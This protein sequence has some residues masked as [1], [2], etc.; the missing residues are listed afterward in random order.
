MSGSVL[1]QLTLDDVQWQNDQWQVNVEHLEV[2]HQWTCLLSL[3]VCVDHLDL[4]SPHIEQLAVASTQGATNDADEPEARSST[5]P[6]TLPVSAI[7]SNLTISNLRFIGL[8]QQVFL[9]ELNTAATL[10][11]DITL[12]HL[13]LGELI[14]NL[15]ASEPAPQTPL[16][17]SYQGL[18]LGQIATPIGV[19]LNKFTLAHLLVTQEEAALM[20]GSLSLSQLSF[21][22]SELALTEL[23]S[24]INHIDLSLSASAQLD[25]NYPVTVAGQASLPMAEQKAQHI[26]LNLTGDLGDLTA[27]IDASG[28]YQAQLSAKLN[29]LSDDLPLTIHLQ[30]PEQ[31]IAPIAQVEGATLGAGTGLIS[32]E[33][34]N[35]RINLDSTAVVAPINDIGVSLQ[36]LVTDRTIALSALNIATLEG[37]LVTKGTAYFEEQLSWTGNTRITN[38]STTRL[39]E[40]GPEHLTGGFNT[41]V[42]MGDDG[43]NL[44]LSAL[45]IQGDYYDLP[46]LIT[47]DAVYSASSDIMVTNLS[48]S[49]GENTLSAIAQII[50]QQYLDGLLVL[51]MTDLSSLYPDISG[52]ITGT[53]SAKGKWDNPTLDAAIDLASLQISST[54]NEALAQQGPLN[55]DVSLKGNL[56]E[57]FLTTS[58]Q[59]PDHKTTMHLQ[60]NWQDDAWVGVLDQTEVNIINTIW[61][62]DSQL[63]IQF[64]PDPLDVTISAHCW[65]SR[66]DGKFCID[67]LT[68]Q[69]TGA[70]WQI[71]GDALPLGLWAF[72]LFPDL[73]AQQPSSTLTFSST[74]HYVPEQPIEA[75]FDLSVSPDTWHLGPK[76]E[77]VVSLEKIT[78]S[79]TYSKDSLAL[80]S[81]LI[82]TEAGTL[83]LEATINSL[84][85]RPTISGEMQVNQW[86]LAPFKPLSTSINTLTG[87]VNGAITFTGEVKQPSLGGSVTIADGNI[88]AEGLPV[89]V[90]QWQQAINFHGQT[91]DFTG[92]FLL[93]DGKGTL[94]GD[95]N[96]SS[97]PIINLVLK[98]DSFAVRQDEIR[99]KV[100]PNLKASI[101]PKTVKVTGSVAIPYA[102]I[103]IDDLP[104]SAVSPS[105]DVHLRG[106]PPSDNFMDLVDAKVMVEID[107]NKT[108][109]VKLDAFGLTASLYGSLEI[110]TLPAL[111]GY[112]DIQLLNG[113]YK[114]YGQNLIIRTGEIQFNG[115]IDQPLLLVEAIRDPDDT[116]DDVVAGIRI[117]GAVEQPNVTLFSEPTMEQAKNLAYLL[118]GSAGLSSSDDEMDEN[119]YA[120]MLLGFGLSSSESLTSNVGESLGIDDLSLTTTGQGDDTK[121]AVSGRIAKNLTIRYGVGVFADTSDG[122]QE[123]ALRYQILPDLYIEIVRSLYTAVDMYYQFTL[124]DR[125]QNDDAKENEAQ[126]P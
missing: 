11:S 85:E 6:L 1:N 112:G 40:N 17:L 19:T 22:G 49:Q 12:S 95:V 99:L 102:R 117:D 37:Q 63:Q 90:N 9:S 14:V 56:K 80:T 125:S 119:A 124:G 110:N 29:L 107:K 44:V 118:N 76:G 104:P 61:A 48:A 30:W 94:S 21:H 71:R 65:H 83:N 116:D 41:A 46:T 34:G 101:S 16:I 92:N 53:V 60:G 115:P 59:V 47:G 8:G 74:G 52:A 79:G 28:Q 87:E 72:E 15:A 78:T 68:A 121:V 66:A 96:W 50:D 62:L 109:D 39:M 55:G 86:Q 73:V 67:S 70:D 64:K 5:T 4:V 108:K 84:T 69:T 114:A 32:G 18:N 106:E 126:D 45:N 27:E 105:S 35:Y 100:S 113:L 10:D 20:D 7:V 97:E 122:G 111:I 38:V 3:Q 98:G 89:T 36:A 25:N 81:H 23:S 58:L 31:S 57:H 13:T 93:G 82:T 33:M 26:A 75:Q 123:V 24:T 43:P 42:S 51:Q 120:A 77:V 88:A 91:A 103:K 54:V 2:A